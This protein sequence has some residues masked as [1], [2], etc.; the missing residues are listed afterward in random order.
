M[1]TRVLTFGGCLAEIQA[2]TDRN[3]A[4]QV[5]AMRRAIESSVAH[6]QK[7]GR[8]WFNE[9]RS[10]TFNTVI[11][12]DTYAFNTATTTE[13]IGAEF[14][15]IDGVWVTFGTG[16]VRE[17]DRVDYS[18]IEADADSQTSNNQPTAYAY[19][20]R[21]IRF[22]YAPIAIYSV[23]IAGHIIVAF[24]TGDDTAD[25]PW[26]TEAFDLIM[27][28]SKAWLYAN[29]WEDPANAALMVA[30][31]KSNLEM[32]RD[33]TWDKLGTGIMRPSSDF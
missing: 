26:F 11:G 23:R 22:D 1:A 20:N 10:I 25:N 7:K 17:M 15:R 3:S 27:S 32:L 31:E 30:V 33:A 8:F 12:T 28:R 6:Y 24:P 9:S 5:L 18:E 4:A 13:A 19:I 29:R 21:G 16:D 14:D 2:D